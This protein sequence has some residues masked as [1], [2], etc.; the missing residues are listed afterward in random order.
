MRL[1]MVCL[2]LCGCKFL[3]L[4]RRVANYTLVAVFSRVFL[5]GCGFVDVSK[6]TAT[7]VKE[8]IL[9][10][11]DASTLAS[12]A[13]DRQ[14]QAAPSGYAIQ[15]MTVASLRLHLPILLRSK[16]TLRV[17]TDGLVPMALQLAK[18]Y[19]H[20]HFY[21]IG[22]PQLSVATNVTW[23]VPTPSLGA[24]AIAGYLAGGIARTGQVVAAV[25]SNGASTYDYNSYYV[26]IR[27]GLHAAFSNATLYPVVSGLQLATPP[28]V[29]IFITNE[30][31]ARVVQR[32][33]T[34]SLTGL[35]AHD[36]AGV[37]N[38]TILA[39]SL[40]TLWSNGLQTLPSSQLLVSLPEPSLNS[41]L[42]G[43][44]SGIGA[45]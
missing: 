16:G 3:D 26:A 6:L 29:T 37:S 35:G 30:P 11:A 36:V 15:T 23:M 40:S 32:S 8:S 9:V 13:V 44:A 39:A 22:T 27:S 21:I 43:G 7:K 33:T 19:P 12:P 20:I 24:A 4:L 17:V 14:L 42:P 18:R 31:T 28:T 38:A 34:I 45:F 5:I 25:Y 41:A 10:L 2:L 1:W